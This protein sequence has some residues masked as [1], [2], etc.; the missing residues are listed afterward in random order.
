LNKVDGNWVAQWWDDG[1]RKKRT[2]GRV[3]TVAKAKA[4]AELDAILAPINSRADAPSASTTWGDFVNHTYLPFYRRKWKF[5][6]RMTNEDRFR[7][8]LTPIYGQRELG[9]FQRDELQDLL[10]AKV[11]A[12]LSHSIVAHLRWDLRQVL[13]MAVQEG[14]LQRN[15]AELLFIPRDARR[16]EHTVMTLKE[17]QTCFAVLDQCERLVAKFAILAGLRPGE[18]FGLKWDHLSETHAEI[19]QRIYRGRIDSPKT[20]HSLRKA[21]LAAG[22]LDDIREWKGI[23]LNNSDD[24]W[25]FP[26]ET[27]KTPMS[28]DNLWRRHMRPQLTSA[29]LGWVDFHVMRR[30]HAT[31]MNEIHD[32]PKMVADQLGHTLDVSQNVY[33]RASVARRKE[34]VDALESALPIM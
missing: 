22:L 14:H 30:T 4:Q 20:S 11:Q 2:L 1:H 17:V 27:G 3:S 24:G 26:S 12:G 32:D 5:S 33:T 23:S 7:V 18:I 19:R 6:T 9:S 16:P 8:H 13:R 29:G 34:A 21:A 15:P 28:R 25:V 10:D 31:L